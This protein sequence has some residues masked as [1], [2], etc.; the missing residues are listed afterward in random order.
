MKLGQLLFHRRLQ[1]GRESKKTL[2]EQVES[3][4]AGKVTAVIEKEYGDASLAR[5]CRGMYSLIPKVGIPEMRNRVIKWVELDV[6]RAV[7]DNRDPTRAR[8]VIDGMIAAAMRTP[9]YVKL[10]EAVGLNED[11]LHLMKNEAL[12]RMKR[13]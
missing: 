12:A 11:H 3:K 4:I 13:A 6:N 5:V 1:E 8:E 10:I 7:K 9:D 2:E